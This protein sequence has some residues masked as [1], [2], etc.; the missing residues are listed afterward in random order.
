MRKT[1]KTN[2]LGALRSFP[3]LFFCFY[4]LHSLGQHF[5]KLARAAKFKK[6]RGT[7]AIPKLHFWFHAAVYSNALQQKDFLP[8]S[9]SPGHYIIETMSKSVECTMKSN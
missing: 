4:W 8:L 9:A 3:F 2:N 5:L 6:K 1:N 7:S